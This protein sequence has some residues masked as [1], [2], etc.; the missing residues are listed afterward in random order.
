MK[1][2][3]IK[4]KNTAHIAR[5]TNMQ[6]SRGF[7]KGFTIVETLVAISI[8]AIALTGP[9]A[10]ISQSL[11]SSYFARDQ[12]TAHYLAQEAVEYVK[13]RRDMNG[14][15][16]LSSADWLSGISTSDAQA[17][18][19]QTL[20][21]EL[22]SNANIKAHLI[23]TNTGYVLKKC[24]SVGDMVCPPLQ[25]DAENRVYGYGESVQSV[26]TDSIFTREITLSKVPGDTDAKREILVSVKVSW[27]T[28]AITNSV[29]IDER[30][31]NWQLELPQV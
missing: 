4:I 27:H 24:Q 25:F 29:T 15:Q 17:D 13:N 6:K 11:K 30:L 19:A 18:G 14:L 8:L 26:P 1:N 5:A 2:K 9:L 16:Q 23:R 3:F 20:L 7:N 21:N 31:Y 22:N 28:A 12:V 10:I